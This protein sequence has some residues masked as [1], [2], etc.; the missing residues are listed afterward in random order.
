MA[1]KPLIKRRLWNMLRIAVFMIRNGLLKRRHL[2]QELTKRGKVFTQNLR[3]LMFHGSSTPPSFALGLRD[4]EFS[5][6]NSPAFAFTGHRYRHLNNYFSCIYPNVDGSPTFAVDYS[7]E[8]MTADTLQSCD[9]PTVEDVGTHETYN[10]GN[11]EE[12]DADDDEEQ[13]DKKSEEFIARF[14]KQ[15]KFQR[16]MSLLQYDEMLA[17]GAN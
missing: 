1:E 13:V 5:C 8:Y 12:L 10:F 9:F 17:R 16:Q 4:Y 7:K 2:Q 3:N 11:G 15:I 14:H 6:S